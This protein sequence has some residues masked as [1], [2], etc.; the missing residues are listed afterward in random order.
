MLLAFEAV[1][2]LRERI[3]DDARVHY[4]Y[5][6]NDKAEIGY[7][8]RFSVRAMKISDLEELKTRFRNLI[9]GAAR[10]AGAEATIQANAEYMPKIPTQELVDSFYENADLLNIP[11][12]EPP[13]K[14]VGSSDTA[15]VLFEVPG[16]GI[17]VPYAPKGTSAHSS[18]WLAAGKKPPAYEAILYAAKTMAGMAYDF[19]SDPARLEAAREQ[20]RTEREALLRSSAGA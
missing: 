12:I 11:D 7:T 10:M 2:L 3:T 9:A 13:R 19:I 15:N 14:R 1:E 20:H 16:I 17:R 5:Q 8:A 6:V 18:E 4:T